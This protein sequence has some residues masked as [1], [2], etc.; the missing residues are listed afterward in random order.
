[1]TSTVTMIDVDAH[2]HHRRRLGRVRAVLKNELSTM[3]Q[4]RP[5][6][7]LI[8]FDFSS[9]PSIYVCAFRKDCCCVMVQKRPREGPATLIIIYCTLLWLAFHL[10]IEI[11]CERY[12][13][14]RR[15][16]KYQFSF[17]FSLLAN[18]MSK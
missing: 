17:F 4:Y 1:M 14:R 2:H 6:K 3:Q 13:E 8:S 10:T 16:E 18:I 15:E 12:A 11:V 9:P 5:S 7:C